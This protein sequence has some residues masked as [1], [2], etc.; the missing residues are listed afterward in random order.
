MRERGKKSFA[1]IDGRMVRFAQRKHYDAWFEEE[2]RSMDVETDPSEYFTMEQVKEHLARHREI[3]R[4]RA[5]VTRK[6]K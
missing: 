3:R 2:L 5:K 4:L 6:C 1:L